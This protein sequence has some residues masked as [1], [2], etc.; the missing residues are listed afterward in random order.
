MSHDLRQKWPLP[1]LLLWAAAGGF[2]LAV[3]LVYVAN[4]QPVYVWD[5][6]LYWNFF[7]EYGEWFKH[8]PAAALYHSVQQTRSADYHPLPIIPL[9]PAQILF[10]DGRATYIATVSILYLFPTCLLISLLVSKMEAA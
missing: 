10:G 1:E 8:E 6:K 5:F 3:A 2:V 9:L 4:E 7:R